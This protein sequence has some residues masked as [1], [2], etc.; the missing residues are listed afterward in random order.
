MAS[1]PDQI[2]QPFCFW[3]QKAH[4][5][6]G[7][8]DEHQTNGTLKLIDRINPTLRKWLVVAIRTFCGRLQ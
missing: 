6:L 4:Q 1:L 3:R 5:G 7:L 2:R 8:R